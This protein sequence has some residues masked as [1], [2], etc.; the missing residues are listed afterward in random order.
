MKFSLEMAKNAI[1]LQIS[2]ALRRLKSEINNMSNSGINVCLF[3][4]GYNLIVELMYVFLIYSEQGKG[5]KTDVSFLPFSVCFEARTRG[6]RGDVS[7]QIGLYYHRFSF[8]GNHIY[9]KLFFITSFAS[10]IAKCRMGHFH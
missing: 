9:I 2:V 7:H 3:D 1:S 5:Q 4:Q 8:I 6:V 10:Q